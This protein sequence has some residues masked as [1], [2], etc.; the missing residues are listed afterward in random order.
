MQRAGTLYHQGR[1]DEAK[2]A[3]LNLAERD[4]TN[5]ATLKQ[6]GT[7]ALWENQC[8][9]AQRRFEDAWRHRGWLERCWPFNAE[10]KYRLGLT[11]YRQDQ[12]VTAASCF[13]E[14]AGPL[15]IGPFRELKALAAQT[16][17]F[18]SNAAYGVEGPEQTR[19]PFLA[20]EPL[21]VIELSVNGF[22]PLNVLIDTGGAELILD[23]D[24]ARRVGARLGGSIRSD[25]AGQK[26][27]LTGLGMIETATFGEIVVRHVPIHVLNTAAMSKS[28][29][30]EIHGILGTRLLQHFLSTIDY[31][32]G[33]LILRRIDSVSKP[34]VVGQGG[35]S[36]IP[37]WLLEM[38]C[39]VAWGSIN[40]LP[41]M[42]FFVD[43]GL[44]GAGFTASEAVLSKAGIT[45][46]WNRATTGIGGAGEVQQ[47]DF[48]VDRL[49][50]GVGADA[51]VETSVPGIA[52]EGGVSILQGKL[53]VQVGG[54]ISHQFFRKRTLTLDFKAMRLIL[55]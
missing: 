38:H 41:P 4:P 25:Y 54:L 36:V 34:K 52:I 19:I 14:A 12:F 27:A 49:A 16:A 29:G 30:R 6:L 39:M 5:S 31:V 9:E 1:F 8:A 32:G 10:L 35:G 42:L 22:G 20:T 44:A 51:V 55:Q 26:T 46:N 21:P 53:G 18:G 43:T 33:A 48:Q 47:V 28:F 2:A 11:H 37:F 13:R 24:V 45:V 15:A 40:D 23:K 17:L 50:L 7:I 3:Y